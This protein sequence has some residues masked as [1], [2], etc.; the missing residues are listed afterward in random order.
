VEE[1]YAGRLEDRSPH[2]TQF[3]KE[4]IPQHYPGYRF[5]EDSPGVTTDGSLSTPHE[6]DL[7]A[8]YKR[9]RAAVR[10]KVFTLFPHVAVEYYTKRAVYINELEEQRLRSIITKAI[11]PGTDGWSDNFPKPQI[12]IKLP[13]PEAGT[14]QLKLTATG[15]LTPPLTPTDKIFDTATGFSTS[16]SP[17]STSST[18]SKPWNVPLYLEALSRTPPLPCT[19]RPPSPKMST[20]ARLL[21][22]FRWT[23]FSPLTGAPSLL[24]TP[25]K[26]FEMQWAD[27]TYAGATEQ[28][29]VKWAQEMWWIVWIRQCHVS[30]VGMWKKRFEKEDMKAEKMREEEEGK[31][32]AEGMVKADKEKIKQRLERLNLSLGLVDE[33]STGA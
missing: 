7:Q 18:P 19:P 22:L 29:L 4:W 25:C 6:Y 3:I 8:W 23:D 14:P 28:D 33:V 26:D 31:T 13:V 30:Y 2:W 9:T 20:E 12:I 16:T 21:C 17:S 1:P 32:R 24:S 27:A 10:E 5:I 15:E 11:P